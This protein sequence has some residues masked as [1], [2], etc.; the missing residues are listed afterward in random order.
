MKECFQ[1]Q[2][3][4]LTEYYW[5]APKEEKWIELRTGITLPSISRTKGFLKIVNGIKTI[6]EGNEAH[7]N[8]G[9]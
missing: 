3:C 5:S 4:T 6:L 2:H 1:V 9:H 8:H 7:P